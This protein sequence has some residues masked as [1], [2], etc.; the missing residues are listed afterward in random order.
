MGACF[1]GRNHECFVCRSSY[2]LEDF[3]LFKPFWNRCL[4]SDHL[5]VQGM[6]H[7]QAVKNTM[8]HGVWGPRNGS[9]EKSE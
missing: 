7:W 8:G 9:F 2:F 5:G 6:P 3:F 1:L 4:G